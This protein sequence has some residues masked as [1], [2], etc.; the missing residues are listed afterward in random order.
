MVSLNNTDLAM[1]FQTAVG[2]QKC[3]WRKF[4]KERHMRGIRVSLNENSS[5]FTFRI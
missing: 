5:L 2:K 1:L 3:V 4:R